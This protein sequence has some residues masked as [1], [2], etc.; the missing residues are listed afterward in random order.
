[1]AGPSTAV[2]PA[3]KGNMI[4]VSGDGFSCA[5]IQIDMA[6]DWRSQARVPMLLTVFDDSTTDRYY[7]PQIPWNSV[8]TAGS[9]IKLAITG[10]SPDRGSY[11]VRV[12]R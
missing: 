5:R 1:M 12:H 11:Q 8:R 2:G 9:G 7:N 4:V 6:P 10:V 3:D